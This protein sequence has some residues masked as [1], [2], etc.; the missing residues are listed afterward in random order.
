MAKYMGRGPRCVVARSS[1]Q[2]R[3]R[4][5]AAIWPAATRTLD[6]GVWAE[7]EGGLGWSGM[8]R[9]RKRRLP[10][11][12]VDDADGVAEVLDLLGALVRE[13]DAELL[14]DLHDLRVGTG[15]E[16]ADDLSGSLGRS[17]LRGADTGGL[18]AAADDV[19]R[20]LCLSLPLRAASS[21]FGPGGRAVSYTHLT[22]PTK[23]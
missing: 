5:A 21:H 17:R 11:E 18:R 3:H 12:V 7:E 19:G 2:G 16:D 20:P 9:K 10:E 1:P 15:S 13:L 6:V 22:L 14:L 23:A 4:R 8:A